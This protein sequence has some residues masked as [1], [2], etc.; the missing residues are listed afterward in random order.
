[1]NETASDITASSADNCLTPISSAMA[2][3]CTIGEKEDS[4]S[5]TTSQHL[6]YHPKAHRSF[7]IRMRQPPHHI[8]ALENGELKMLDKLSVG[9][10]WLWHCDKK[11]GWYGFRN[12]VSGTYLGHN[13]DKIVAE[14]PHHESDENF[15]PERHEE[16]G[17]ILLRKDNDGLLQVAISEDG[18]SLVQG[19]EGPAWDFIEDQ[20]LH[21]RIHMYIPS[22]VQ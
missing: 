2:D 10:G 1:M 11:D 15:I 16:G 13:G 7:M 22:S 12:T 8:I 19:Q 6:E 3:N 17:Y 21:T 14:A 18:N 4:I 9:S 5:I 20:T